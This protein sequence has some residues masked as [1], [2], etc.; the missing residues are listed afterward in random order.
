MS[1]RS[2][3]F[4]LPAAGTILLT[5]PWL[6]GCGHSSITSL[7]QTPQRVLAF[8]VPADCATVYTRLAT[9]AHQR[10]SYTPV[11]TYQPAVSA[12]LAP[13][14]DSAVVTVWN[15]GGL[16]LQCMLNADLRALD[17]ARTEVHIAC[18][19]AAYQKEAILWRHWANTPLDPASGAPNEAPPR[20]EDG[21]PK[22]EGGGQKTD[23]GGQ[24]KE[25]G[26]S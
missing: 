19:K 25:S 26:A 14:R 12:R 24:T 4:R 5:L 2:S 1:T 9:R 18:A 6:A 16:S 17:P 8:E 15:A 23:D 11:V 20:P 7:R 21:G 22:T 10:Y 3:R 13:A